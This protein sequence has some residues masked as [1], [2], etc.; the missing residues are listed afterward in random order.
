MLREAKATYLA[1]PAALGASLLA[2]ALLS[3]A[4]CGPYI[5]N[6]GRTHEGLFAVFSGTPT[7]KDGR[8]ALDQYLSGTVQVAHSIKSFDKTNG[9]HTDAFGVKG[10][11]MWYSANVRFPDGVHPEC[12][13]NNGEFMGFDCGFQLQGNGVGAIAR[14]SEASFKGTISFQKT[15]AGWMPSIQRPTVTQL[16]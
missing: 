2:T 12:V 6:K 16:N 3:L 4:G 14:G 13:S 5:D 9:Q 15:E 1:L 11:V 7:S 8:A 10:Y